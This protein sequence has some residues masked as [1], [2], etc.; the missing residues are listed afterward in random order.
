MEVVN[1]V[2]KFLTGETPSESSSEQHTCEQAL[3]PEVIVAEGISELCMDSVA[4]SV[5]SVAFNLLEIMDN[6]NT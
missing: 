2:G 4:G 1:E 6:V 5:I 3:N